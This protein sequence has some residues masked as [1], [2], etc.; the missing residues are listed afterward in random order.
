MRILIVSTFFP[1]LNSI[2]SL[3]PYSWAKEWGRQGHDVT[4]LTTE[5]Q[6]DKSVSLNVEHT[7]Y[8]LI[9]VPLPRF[10][11]QAKS[12]HSQGISKPGMKQLFKS[13]FERARHRLGIF[14]ACRM[15]DFADLWIKPALNAIKQETPYDVVVSSAGPYSVH[16]LSYILKKK[17][18]AKKWV[19]DYRDT[20]SNNYFY[21]GIF[22]LNFFEKV[23][24]KKILRYADTITTVSQPLADIFI[25]KYGQEK[26]ATVPNGFDPDDL[27]NID[28]NPAFQ[29]DDKFRIVH[30]GS[31]YLG[32]RDPSP[33]FQAISELGH[34]HQEKLKLFEVVFVGANQA[35]LKTLIERYQVGEWVKHIG[36]VSRERALSMQRDAHALL[37]LPWN[38]PNVDG[39]VTGKIFEYFYSNTPIIALGAS[40]ME[41]SQK[42]I[43]EANAG[44][45][46]HT[47]EEIKH[48]LIEALQ[49]PKK[50]LS[51]VDDAY[52]KRYDRSVIAEQFLE[53]L[54]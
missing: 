28:A 27:R 41:L 18:I 44:K 30:T 11:H 6:Q 7:G 49:H 21:P 31:I 36:F 24:E 8:R 29:E 5:K 10:I 53:L 48:Y 4:V 13:L 26:V 2:A 51:S 37:F 47:V 39:I 20:W 33:L 25:S 23:L 54:K 52:L 3:R 12:S 14:N 45:V 50:I 32:R 38:D 43:L 46:F 9:E 34:T 1:P 22:P 15:P 19:A 17:G 42:M 16:I 40:H 35:N